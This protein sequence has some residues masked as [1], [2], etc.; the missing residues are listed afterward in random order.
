MTYYCPNCWNEI[1]KG[2]DSCPH[3]GTK[4]SLLRQEPFEKKLIRSLNHPEPKTV[5]RAINILGILKSKE[6]LTRLYEILQTGKD[7]FIISEAVKS[8]LKIDGTDNAI[9]KIKNNVR[10]DLGILNPLKDYYLKH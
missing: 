3:C 2:N 7:P 4:Q 9:M 6:A 8:I 1:Q 5:V 10:I